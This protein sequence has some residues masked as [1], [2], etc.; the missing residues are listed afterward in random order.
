MVN[1][2]GKNNGSMVKWWLLTW[3][4]LDFVGMTR[5]TMVHDG[6]LWLMLKTWLRRGV[7]G[8][9]LQQ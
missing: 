3:F 1:T 5:L 9:A 6:H 4:L 7:L 8:I 2:M